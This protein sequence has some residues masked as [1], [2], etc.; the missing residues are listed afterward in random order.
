MPTIPEVLAAIAA[1]E[2]EL[3]DLYEAAKQVKLV[4][5]FAAVAVIEGDALTS[6]AAQ[7]ALQDALQLYIK[8]ISDIG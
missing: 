3:D 2:I 6:D 1:K 5:Y 8:E 4:E 7:T